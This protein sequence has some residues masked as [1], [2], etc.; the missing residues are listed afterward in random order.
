MMLIYNE[1]FQPQFSIYFLFLTT[2]T[3]PSKLNLLH[4]IILPILAET[5]DQTF[6][7]AP[8]YPVSSTVFFHQHES[9]VFY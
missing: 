7:L 2:A 9:L 1:V 6:S 5:M 3:F 4:L 8:C